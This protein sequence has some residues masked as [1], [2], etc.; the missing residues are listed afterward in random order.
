VAADT[1]WVAAEALV[2]DSARCATGTAFE[3]DPAAPLTDAGTPLTAGTALA[4]ADA[5]RL[6]ARV[7]LLGADAAR[8]PPRVLL[9][10]ADTARLTAGTTLLVV[11]AAEVGELLGR[12]ALCAAVPAL[13]V[14]ADA[15][16]AVPADDT[17]PVA[18]DT[19]SPVAVDAALGADADVTAAPR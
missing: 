4:G 18:V 1:T 8:L 5:A 6:T 12:A 19:A 17:L 11:D 3:D 14:A 7:L 16:P 9:L 2:A 15:A 10:G 13:P